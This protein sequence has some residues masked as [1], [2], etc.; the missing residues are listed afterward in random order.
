MLNA[1]GGGEMWYLIENARFI[2]IC[3]LDLIAEHGER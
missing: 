2:K 3:K 1:R